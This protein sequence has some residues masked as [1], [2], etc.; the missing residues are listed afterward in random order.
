MRNFMSPEKI[1]LLSKLQH[2]EHKWAAE[3]MT[4]GL[5]TVEMLKTENDIRSIRN[6]IKYQDVQETLAAAS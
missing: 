3:L 1:K 2:L 4:H 5:C 6:L